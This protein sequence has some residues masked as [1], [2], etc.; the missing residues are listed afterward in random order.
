L[1][2]YRRLVTRCCVSLQLSM[3]LTMLGHNSTCLTSPLFRPIT[4]TPLLA[5][6]RSQ[7]FLFINVSAFPFFLLLASLLS[8]RK[9]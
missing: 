3:Y 7:L 9:Q 8:V 4:P 1:Q 2:Y 5:S 6:E